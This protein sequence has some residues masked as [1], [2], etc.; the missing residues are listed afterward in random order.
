MS[1]KVGV[2]ICHC[3][4]NIA[5]TVDVEE[6]A[7]WSGEQDNVEVA[8]E[9]KFMCS[10]LGQDLIEEDIKDKGLTRVVVAS[11]SPHMH[12]KTFRTACERGGLNPFLFEMANIREHDSWTTDDTNAATQKAK[13]LTKAA[14]DR[15][16][17][18]QPLELMPVDI[19]P[20]TLVVGGGIAG[21]TSALELADAGYH[22][23]LVEREP[24]IGGHMAQLDKTFPTLDCSACILTPKM[25]DVDQH[26]NITLLTYSEVEAVGGHL[27]NFNVTVRK[28]AR[29][30]DE[31][32]CTGCG[33]CIEKCPFKVTDNVFEAGLGIRKVIYRP[34]PQAVPKYPV[35]DTENCVYFQRGKCKAC[36]I[37]CP[38]EPNSI[39]FEQ[40][41]ELLQ[42]DVGNIILATGYDLFDVSKI[43]Q[44]GYGKLANVF[45]SLEFERMVN[46]SG[47]TSG[48][49]VMRDME[50]PPQSVAIIHCVGS[51]DE[52]YHKYCSKVCCMYSLKFAHL[53]HER[54]PEAEV[55][56]C[57]IDMRTPGK[58]YE[59]F[60]NRLLNEDTHFIRGKVADVTDVARTDDEEG[61]LIVQVEDTLIGKQR[62]IP[63]DMVILSPAMEAR[64]DSK[65][66]SQLFKMGCDF[67][68][69]FVE[70]HPK[71]DPV[72]TMTEG[73]LIAG[74]CQGPKDVP[75]SVSQGAAA[76]ARVAGLISRGTVMM[77]PVRA[78]V[79]QE[80]CSGCRIC[81][82]MCPYNAILFH[83]D[84]MVSE[85]VTALCQGCGTCVAACPSAAITGAHFTN[86]Q[87]TSQIEGI[88]WDVRPERELV[89][90]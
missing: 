54:I 45:T 88:L 3:G 84:R 78:S 24:S 79:N 5:K 72:A 89:T 35:I 67:D 51:R 38:T 11:C 29:Y 64:A 9:Y 62:R 58:G 17:H 15:V 90:A 20:N 55:Y 7:T 70:R 43:P 52:N 6:V 59:E 47:P 74:A 57:Y 71:L 82:N 56:N 69:F 2:Y 37:F 21:I 22:V 86:D 66:V 61:K 33:I 34:F 40:E 44:Y 65:E 26:P 28:K 46:A 80:A 39:D 48:K 53:V 23:Y 87:I 18:H 10:S 12:E 76:A 14:I 73:I 1:E 8:R 36:Q 68:G 77:E 75:D 32:H 49:I 31:E 27:G 41:D 50:T 19:N 63:V 4:T 81:N 60:Y 16:V 83:E 25:V 13:A 42:I 30:V 85:V